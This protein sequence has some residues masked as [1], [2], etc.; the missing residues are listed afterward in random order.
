ML[1][2]KLLRHLNESANDSLIIQ[3]QLLKAQ[4]R[5]LQRHLPPKKR[6]VFSEFCKLE[7]ARLAKLL[8]PESL[9]DA[10]LII[11]PSTLLRWY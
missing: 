11:R 3:N 7:M 6:L 8:T 4:I 2:A 5:E 9:E 1:W 10:C